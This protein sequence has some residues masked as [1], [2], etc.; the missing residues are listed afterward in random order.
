[1]W[2]ANWHAGWS[3]QML[4]KVIDDMSPWLKNFLENG[5]LRKT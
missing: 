1:L 4:P 3:P 2:T 5:K